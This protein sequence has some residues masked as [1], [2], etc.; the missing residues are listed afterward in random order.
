MIELACTYNTEDCCGVNI[1]HERQWIAG[2]TQSGQSD[3][4]IAIS[5]MKMGDDETRI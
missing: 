2:W 1:I 3:K 4:L 5:F